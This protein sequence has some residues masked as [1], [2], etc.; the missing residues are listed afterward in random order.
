V[1]DIYDAATYQP[2]RS[3]GALLSRVRVEMLSALDHDLATDKR[4]ASLELSAAQF[5]IIANLA[6][7][8]APLSASDLCK[9]ISYDAGAM[10]RMLDRL[11]GK[12][13]IR[14]NRSVQDRRLMH[15]ELTDE[16][17][18]TYPRMREISLTV[19][20][21]FL[22]GFTKAEARQLESMLTRMLENASGSSHRASA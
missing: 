9:G 21:R 18:A 2:K 10:T 13:L 1:T 20:N 8:E 5:I 15:L 12:G 6:A 16:G 3:V 4:L 22:H 17:R 11:E 19:A 7:A 14:R